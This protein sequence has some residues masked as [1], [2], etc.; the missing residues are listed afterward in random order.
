[1]HSRHQV[2][3]VI[4]ALAT[5]LL[6]AS[7]REAKSTVT[8]LAPIE[9]VIEGDGDLGGIVVDGTGTVFVSEREAGKVFRIATGDQP[10]AV[11]EGLKQPVGLTL[12]GHGGL[13][14]VEGGSRRILR[15]AEDGEMTT[16]ASGLKRPRW[17]GAAPDGSVYVTARG[18]IA[19]REEGDDD[20]SEAEVIARLAPAGPLRVFAD[21]F[22]GLQGLTV[23]EE[24]LTVVARGREG[25]RDAR[26]TLY[27]IPI[28]PDGRPGPLMPLVANQLVEPRE[29]A[30]DRIGARFVSAKSLAAEPWHRHIV[31]R[32]T[33]DGTPTLF[34]EGLEDPQG[35]AFGEDGSLYLADGRSG[36]IVRFVAPSPP[37]LE[38]NPPAFTNQRQLTLRL[39][40]EAG[41]LITVLGAQ[42]P[43]S[44]VADHGGSA[45]V[46]V[47]L[48]ANVENHLLLFAT[49]A[50]GRGLTSAPLEITVVHD[51]Q[52]P[53]IALVTPRTGTLVRGLIPTEALAFDR[54]GIAD[55]EFRLDGSLVGLDA[56]A[57]YQ[58]TF[59]TRA[60]A[61]GPR[62]LSAVARDRAGNVASA[63]AQ[64]T[65]DNTP[66][67]V[68][69]VKPVSGS[70]VAGTA[71]VIVEARD[72]TSGVAR[73][74]V[75]VNGMPRFMAEAPPYRFQFDPQNLGVGPHVLVAA[76]TDRAG[77]RAQSAPVSITLSGIS[78]G[79]T[80]P[81]EGAQVPAGS[82]LVR[83][84]VE[85]G[86]AEVGVAVNGIPAAVQGATFA[87]VVPVRAD[88]TRLTAVATTASGMTASHSVSIGVSSTP[89][90]GVDL[91]VTSSSGVAPLTVTFSL[92]NSPGAAAVALD[93]D[94]NGTM[95][96]TGPTLEGQTFTYALPGFYLPRATVTDTGGIQFSVAGVV[97]VLAP[98]QMD[99]LL[100]GKWDAMKAALIRNDIEGAIQFF[101]PEQQ[102]RFRTLF[103]A[104]SAQI[105]KIVQDM[106]DIQLVY[107]I[108]NQ[109]K[110]RLRRIQPYGGQLV[111]MT[112]Y[113]YFIQDDSGRWS[114][115]GF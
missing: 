109:A 44:A 103:T 15:L 106:Q 22:R 48:R 102:P 72:E 82:I 49:A 62:T 64:L 46:S 28:E 47:M 114:I 17:I 36:R 53:S 92:H 10:R 98:D 38:D 3:V 14:I 50:A 21:G 23:E 76:A 51:D 25:E 59:D 65:I 26:G 112:Y 6:S 33:P 43:V 89:A 19:Q 54:T 35:L 97:N 39:Q 37:T 29:L 63:A 11:V 58:M 70:I 41:A 86:G 13:L 115:E 45:S 99:G 104:L 75:A 24:A 80:E 60:V 94:G 57:P 110:Y 55:V 27:V 101:T 81:L 31:L 40:A 96:F 73:V 32:V 100:K 95:D 79:I 105:A 2:S 84:R 18:L 61:D 4:L 9:L 67:E 42:L 78:I 88:T 83:G 85:A 8:A 16:L 108:E 74:E 52:P 68:R 20:E 111:T 30:S 69:V 1:M 66:P 77:N 34:A 12:D 56:A 107:L 90:Q 71:E 91:L 7:A 93:F 5:F 113:V 87:A